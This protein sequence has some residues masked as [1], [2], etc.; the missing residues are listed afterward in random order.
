MNKSA[1]NRDCTLDY[2]RGLAIFMIVLGHLYFYS[3]KSYESF[4]WNICNTIQISVFI[5]VSGYLAHKSIIKY[6]FVDFMKS[7]IIRLIIPFLSFFLLWEAI[8]GINIQNTILFITDEFKQGFWFMIVLFELM[9]I[10]AT[11]ALL[12]KKW[13]INRHY[14]DIFWLGLINIYHFAA[15]NLDTMNQTLSLNL[16]WHYYPIFMIGVFKERIQC[17]FNIKY[18][19]LY[20]IIY[21]LAF[22]CMYA[23]HVTIMTALC[24][25]ASVFVFVSYFSNVEKKIFVSA[26]T[27]AGFYSLQIYL[28]HILI[29]ISFYDYI[30]I[31]KNKLTELVLFSLLAYLI[32][33]F[34]IL[35]SK[36]ISKL[37][38]LNFFLFG[39]KKKSKS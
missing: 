4:I 38:I 32:C 8:N 27:N 37:Q 12:A 9:V 18:T 23:Q 2:L 5:F 11:N 16:L 19:Y 10:L 34:L 22:Y 39:V 35:L 26:I 21:C 31:I 25:I 6:S 29:L 24:N 28:M 30:P 13:K 20:F 15:T 1:L 3:G 7:R 17:L 33:F 14:L 36:A